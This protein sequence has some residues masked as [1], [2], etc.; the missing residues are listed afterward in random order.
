MKTFKDFLEL[1]ESSLDPPTETM[2]E[3]K[4]VEK[5]SWQG[6]YANKLDRANLRTKVVGR[7]FKESESAIDKLFD[8]IISHTDAHDKKL[9]DILGKADENDLQRLHHHKMASLEGEHPAMTHIRNELK[10]RGIKPLLGK[11]ASA[12]ERGGLLAVKLPKVK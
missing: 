8:K 9:Q 6:S 12:A 11:E 3:L 5:S 2:K 10:R 4:K 1:D 7:I